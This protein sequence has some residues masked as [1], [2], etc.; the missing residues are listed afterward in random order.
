MIKRYLTDAI[1]QLC[2][3]NH[4]IAF[5]SGPRQCGKTTLAK[6]L[7]AQR[8]ESSYHNWD[9]IEFR[10]I[11]TKAPKQII[12][13]QW[14]TQAKRSTPLIVLDEIHK[15]RAWKSSLKG[16]YDTARL[17]IDILVTGS[18][19]LNVYKKG[20]D[21]LMGRYYNFRLHPFSLAELAGTSSIS[22][23]PEQIKKE[24]FEIDPNS[25]HMTILAPCRK[26]AY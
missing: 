13:E 10:R 15:A 3:E 6:M 20:S 16:V 5:L 2:F 1:N 19:R 8:S 17:P 9:D 12:A 24:I 11:W 26:E 21:S 7:L 22:K 23:D 14:G 18:A 4:K 25:R